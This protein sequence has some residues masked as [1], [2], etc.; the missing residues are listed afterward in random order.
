MN[1]Q[2][3][4]SKKDSVL[5]DI[6]G[7]KC[8]GC[9]RTVEQ[10]LCD[11]PNVLKASVNLV[12]GTAWI[13]LSS[14]E[15]KI[16]NILSALAD[17]GFPSKERNETNLSSRTASSV[18]ANQSWWNQWK[19]LMIALGLLFLSI[20]GHL[21]E[22]GNIDLPVI[23]TLPFHAC[24]ATFALFG[25]GLQILKKG[26][27]SGLKLNPTMDSLVGLG[28][29]SAYIASL[30]ALIWP[31]VSWPCFFNE[32]VML[33][34]FVL[35][36]RFL[37][38]RAR[39]RTN[40]ALTELAQLQPETARIFINQNEIREVRVGALKPAE[41]IQL[42]AGDRVPVDGVVIEGNSAVDVSS[43]TGESLPLNASPGTELSSGS[44]NLE[45]TLIFKV[46]RIGSDS[47][48]ARIVGLVEEAQARKAPIQGLA[49]RVAGKFCYGVIFLSIST[50][51]FWWQIGVKLWPEVLNAS[52]QGMMHHHGVHA[53]LGSQ[54]QT[55]LGLA[56]Q[57]SI[58]VLVVACPCAL[59]LATPT[60]ITVAAGIAAKRG[61]L[62]R[63]GDIIER[64]ASIKQIIFDKT[65]TLTIGRPLVIECLLSNDEERMLQLAASLEQ[66]SRHP[67]AHA[68]L[69]KN[70]QQQ[71]P[72]LNASVTKTFPGEG[73]AGELDGIDGT[74]RIGK[75]E[76]IRSKGIKL[77]KGVERVLDDSS[78]KGYSIVAVALNTDL[79]GLIS[80]DDQVRHDANTSLQRLR[81]QG[82]KLNML[83]GDRRKAVERLGEKLGFEIDELGWG[84]L[85]DQKLQRIKEL[86]IHMPI[87]MVGDGINDAP[88]L[89]ASD[90]GI[91]VGT[92]TQVAKDSADLVLLGDRLEALPEAL[93]LAKGTMY[94]IQQ[95]LFWAFGYNMIALPLAAGVLL[96]QFGLLLS[97][98]LA[99]FLMALSSIT[100]VLNALSLKGK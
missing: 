69:Q 24:L 90:L 34:G 1:R 54:A 79:L 25:P 91:A 75:P 76:W 84:L 65:G 58:A 82:L 78:T 52:G 74:I 32:P 40:K 53:A 29:S 10:L 80:I 7:M 70:Q 38:E 8:G 63:G 12:T 85:P 83:S 43:L 100:V 67:I 62:F 93:L 21:A 2:D 61:W 16:D 17:H 44:L 77:Q 99:A 66:N 55:P 88:A 18:A 31:Q 14:S 56:L 42:L 30:V 22:G 87:A 92:G 95:N 20:L 97:P 57:L 68:I 50:F 39:F 19:Q 15:K 94:K 86:Q 49:D 72:L 89:A 5:L 98:P 28:V 6:E 45:A 3:V 37:E 71:L 73:I 27:Q 59:G 96:P 26:L 60:V 33:L 11:Q 64:A 48:L 35:V 36:G 4:T 47:A 81:K 9:V 46:T 51:I 23:G 41:H 13:D